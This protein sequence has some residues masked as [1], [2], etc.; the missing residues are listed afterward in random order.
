MTNELPVLPVY[1]APK[2][3]PMTVQATLYLSL[4]GCVLWFIVVL[5]MK[6]EPQPASFITRSGLGTSG[7]SDSTA[8]LL[9][10]S[11]AMY[12]FGGTDGGEM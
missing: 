8:W 11:N 4:I 1:F 2:K 10:I 6:G 5:A 9:G 7:W 3:V 12:T